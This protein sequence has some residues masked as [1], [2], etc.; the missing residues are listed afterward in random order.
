MGCGTSKGDVLVGATT[1]SDD[2]S[3]SSAVVTTSAS[4]VVSPWGNAHVGSTHLGAPASRPPDSATTIHFSM[5][6]HEYDA[7]A[8]HAWGKDLLGRCTHTRVVLLVSGLKKRLIKCWLDENQMTGDIVAQMT[9]G[10]DD[11]SVVIV[12]VTY[13]YIRKVSGKGPKGASDN[14]KLEFDYTMRRK[15][16]ELV[17]TVV[18]EPSCLN[19]REWEGAVGAQ[20]GGLLYVDLSMD[21]SHEGFE[22]GLDRVA[23]EVKDRQKRLAA[24]PR[25]PVLPSSGDKS[26][27][28]GGKAAARCL[29]TN[30]CCCALAC[31]E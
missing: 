18:M 29:A 10:I 6:G 20:V 17:V 21:D 13:E 4:T 23:K 22:R 5:V 25:D 1:T 16:P 14:C 2:A 15:G 9:Q 12:C 31:S 30:T 19:P 3:S 28:A 26:A 7:F 8:T 11:S 27:Q 24:L